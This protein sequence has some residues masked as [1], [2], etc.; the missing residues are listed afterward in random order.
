MRL[1]PRTVIED[2][3]DAPPPQESSPPQSSR[4]L[5]SI[6]ELRAVWASFRNGDVVTCPTDAA[7]L[8]LS[9]DASA[10]AYRFVCTRCGTASSWFES[11]PNGHIEFRPSAQLPSAG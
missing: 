6:E 9:V 8:A 4:P 10:G 7:P 11:S 5:G 3:A 1:R 2:M